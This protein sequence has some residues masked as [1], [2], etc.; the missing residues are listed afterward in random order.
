MFLLIYVISESFR[1]CL[2]A[3]Q[4]SY[5]IVCVH[6]AFTNT[7]YQN[8]HHCCTT[9]AQADITEQDARINK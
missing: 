3:V 4:E 1:S 8:M 5:C 9:A 6:I 7:T 2:H